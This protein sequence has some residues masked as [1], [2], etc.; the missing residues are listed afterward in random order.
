MSI[1]Q[2]IILENVDATEAQAPAVEELMRTQYGTLD[3]LGLGEFRREARICL[4]AIEQLEQAARGIIVIDEI[5][6]PRAVLESLG[7]REYT[8]GATS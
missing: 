4:R 6:D 2:R 8:K 1:Y 3:H 7:H 5:D